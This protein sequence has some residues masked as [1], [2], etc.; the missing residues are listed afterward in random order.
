MD[1]EWALKIVFATSEAVP[2]AK[3]GGLAEVCGPLPVALSRLGHELTVVMPGYRCVRYSGQPIEPL[4]ITFV[5]PIGTKVMAGRLAVSRMPDSSVRVVF[6][7]QDQYFD[8]NNLYTEG[9]RDY[10]DNCE[11]FV[12][13]SRA[14]LEVIRLLDLRPEIVHCHDWQTGLIPAYLALEY[15]TLPR[16]RQIATLFTIHNMSYQGRFWHWD[17]ILTGLDWKHFNW[18]ELEFYGDL[19]LLKA[20]IVY[21]DALSTV[22][23]QYALDIQTPEYGYGMDGVLRHRRDSLFGILNG[24]DVKIWNPATDRW[25]P[26]RYDENTWAEGKAICKAELQRELGLPQLP[27][28]PL[29]GKVGRMIEQKGSDLLARLIAEWAPRTNIQWAILGTGVP[30]LEAEFCRLAA[31]FPDKV[32]VRVEFSEALAH[33]IIAGADIFVMPSRFEPCGLNQMYSMRYGTIPVVRATG[34]LKDTVVD[35]TPENI[36]AGRAT[37]FVLEKP[38]LEELAEALQRACQ[39]FHNKELW[40]K[41]ALAGMRQDWSWER[42]AGQ[43]IE[44]YQ[45]I[46]N[47]RQQN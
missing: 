28:V 30:E 36:E 42:R 21:A 22:S 43:Y 31:E 17:M 20:G 14:V 16:Y 47:R 46:R 45:W 6:V 44:L 33:R 3:T 41:L 4:G 8:R 12:F 15:H 34:G 25:L 26:A 29:V 23:P 37:G 24:I 10:P 9:G 1:G 11:R 19:S 5:V 32:A 2:F 38:T 39:A 18:R 7:E 13:F 40:R 27:D 35:A